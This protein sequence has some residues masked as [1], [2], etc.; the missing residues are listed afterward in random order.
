M[1]LAAGERMNTQQSVNPGKQRASQIA[2][3]R[4]RAVGIGNATVAWNPNAAFRIGPS[5]PAN[6]GRA[7]QSPVKSRQDVVPTWRGEFEDDFISTASAPSANGVV[8]GIP[9]NN[10]GVSIGRRSDSHFG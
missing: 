2:P 7:K 1:D 9:A 6:V 4:R 3:A 5:G 10:F 8:A